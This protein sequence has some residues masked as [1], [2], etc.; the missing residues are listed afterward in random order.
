MFSGEKINVTEQ[1]AVLHTALRAPVGERIVV[2]GIDIVPEVH[3]VL[4]NGRLF[5][6]GARRP[7]R[8]YTGKRIRNVINIGIR[9]L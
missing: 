1:R 7:W 8:G 9:R 5:A 6:P 4:I 3:A 2:D